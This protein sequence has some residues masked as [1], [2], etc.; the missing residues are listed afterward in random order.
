M[1][2]DTP[3][4]EL[5]RR[6]RAGD[7]QAAAELVQRFEPSVRRAIRMRMRD[8][9][10]RRTLDSVDICQSV[11][12]SFFVRAAA[13]QFD[14]DD[15]DQVIKLLV[16]MAR[17]KLASQA[18][19]SPHVGHR[20]QPL[21]PGGLLEQQLVAPGATPF[22]NLAGR[23]LLE[24]F[25]HH[26]SAGER[27]LVEWRNEGRPWDDIAREVGESPDALRKRLTRALDRAAQELGLDDFK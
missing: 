9:L 19:K 1:A 18:R 10:L 14:I 2:S 23:E 17:N 15:P 21:E 16:V 27:R 26:L 6:L 5:I 13:G 20:H 7:E 3:F 22:R 11:L 8:P 12:A 24:K 4:P 25:Y